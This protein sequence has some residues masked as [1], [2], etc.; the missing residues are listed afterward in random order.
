MDKYIYLKKTS[1]QTSAVISND[2]FI[3]SGQ[4]LKYIFEER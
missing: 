2:E 1:T 4:S 3:V